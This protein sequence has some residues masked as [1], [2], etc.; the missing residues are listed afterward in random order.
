MI[1]NVKMDL[2][3]GVSICSERAV[4]G[5]VVASIC[6]G[7]SQLSSFSSFPLLHGTLL[8]QA[9][10]VFLHTHNCTVVQYCAQHHMALLC[11]CK[12]SAAKQHKFSC[13]CCLSFVQ[14]GLL[15]LKRQG[16]P[17]TLQGFL[18][19]SETFAGFSQWLQFE[20]HGCI[21]FFM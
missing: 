8:M 11:M 16:F 13:C 2:N 9:K 18:L 10:Q 15:F 14:C 12:L 1:L 6:I 3:A 19:G 5:P 21:L 20:N 17:E 4:K 7:L